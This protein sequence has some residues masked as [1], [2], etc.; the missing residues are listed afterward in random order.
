M[1][2]T[3]K[4]KSTLTL[5]QRRALRLAA[6]HGGTLISIEGFY[7]P[8]FALRAEKVNVTTVQALIA[9]SIFEPH[10]KKMVRLTMGGHYLASEATAEAEAAQAAVEADRRKRAAASKGPRKPHSALWTTETRPNPTAR[11][12]P[13]A[14]N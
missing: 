10:G 2:A 4:K 12:L 8:S 13:Y 7:R 1:S 5:S 3:R 14:D 6:A 11:R 9:R